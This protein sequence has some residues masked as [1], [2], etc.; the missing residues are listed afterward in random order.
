MWELLPKRM[1]LKPWRSPYFLHWVGSY[2]LTP[3]FNSALLAA[4]LLGSVSRMYVWCWW[5]TFQ[6]MWCT[7]LMRNGETTR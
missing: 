3:A 7:C 5:L 4:F 6:G 2:S 1:R